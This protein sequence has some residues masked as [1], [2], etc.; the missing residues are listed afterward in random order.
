MT[1]DEVVRYLQRA[2]GHRIGVHAWPNRVGGIGV[3]LSGAVTRVDELPVRGQE[4]RLFCQVGEEEGNGFHLS[5]AA[6]I[7][8]G[9]DFADP[10]TLGLVHR[11][12]R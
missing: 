1:F 3:Q 8:A 6:F 9:V 12:G 5:A 4:P 11:L 10:D 2:E 7:K